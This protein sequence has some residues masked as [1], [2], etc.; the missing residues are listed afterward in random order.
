MKR[1]WSA[2]WRTATCLSCSS[3]RFQFRPC[4]LDTLITVLSKDRPCW[5]LGLLAAPF[6]PS[7]SSY[8]CLCINQE[9]VLAH[10]VWQHFQRLTRC[11]WHI[12]GPQVVVGWNER[13][14]ESVNGS[15][16]RAAGPG[17]S[18]RLGS[19][20]QVRTCSVAVLA[21]GEAPVLAFARSED[22]V[23]FSLFK[24]N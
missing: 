8:Y 5:H 12:V 24:C 1:G 13:L 17:P 6:F 15:V 16:L 20:I 4:A 11:T 7:W 22:T 23:T 3:C 19:G 18:G 2:H 9:S 14:E 21:S 10:L